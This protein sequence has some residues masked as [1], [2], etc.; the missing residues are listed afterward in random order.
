M[1]SQRD[2]I[3]TRA[4]GLSE[5]AWAGVTATG[6][7]MDL[8]MPDTMAG[9]EDELGPVWCQV[10]SEAQLQ[11]LGGPPPAAVEL[12]TGRFELTIGEPEQWVPAHPQQEA[13]RAHARRILQGSG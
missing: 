9:N 3:R 13:I 4:S 10:L 5:L 6:Q 1:R 7:S 11:R 2:L 12:P 8:L